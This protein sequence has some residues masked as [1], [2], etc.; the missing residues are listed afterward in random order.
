MCDPALWFY[1][2]S[3]SYMEQRQD[4]THAWNTCRSNIPTHPNSYTPSYHETRRNKEGARHENHPH[5]K[6]TNIISEVVSQC[7]WCH[8]VVACSFSLLLVFLESMCEIITAYARG[9]H[10]LMCKMKG[11]IHLGV[12]LSLV[13]SHLLFNIWFAFL[14]TGTFHLTIKAGNRAKAFL[15]ESIS[16]ISRTKWET[17]SKVEEIQH[18]NSTIL[19]DWNNAVLLLRRIVLDYSRHDHQQKWSSS[20]TPH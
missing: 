16:F 17:Y 14:H 8:H 1:E 19:T 15:E 7:T 10:T 6:K 11:T 5:T 9:S 13:F 20:Q 2:S 4:L 3:I 12:S 18:F